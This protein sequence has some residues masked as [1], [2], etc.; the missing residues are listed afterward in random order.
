[1]EQ[2]L[3]VGFLSQEILPFFQPGLMSIFKISSIY[4][5]F[6]PKTNFEK[7]GSLLMKPTCVCKQI[8]R[9][10]GNSGHTVVLI[11]LIQLSFNLDEFNCK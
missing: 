11:V 7:N 6:P 8:G 10:E 9:D 4:F 5:R 2:L 3:V 1:M